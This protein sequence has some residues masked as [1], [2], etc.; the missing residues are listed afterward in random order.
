MSFICTDGVTCASNSKS[1]KTANGPPRNYGVYKDEAVLGLGRPLDS[2]TMKSS[3]VAT[4]SAQ[5]AGRGQGKKG[6]KGE[7][8]SLLKP[9]VRSRLRVP[10]HRRGGPRRQ[11]F[12]GK[13]RK[14][15]GVGIMG[16]GLVPSPTTGMWGESGG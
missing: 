11:D 13:E 5:G 12:S 8:P 3:P 10:G 9:A 15:P 4:N 14:L 7:R 6:E 1:A 2:Q 16:R